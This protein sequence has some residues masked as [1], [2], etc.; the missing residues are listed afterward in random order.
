MYLNKC[1]I[2]IQREKLCV[3]INYR[4]DVIKWCLQRINNISYMHE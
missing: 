1:C 4:V 3:Q 2:F